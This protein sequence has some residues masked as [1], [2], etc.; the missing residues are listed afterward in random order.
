MIDVTGAPVI[1]SFVDVFARVSWRRAPRGGGSC[2]PRLTASLSVTLTVMI[3]VAMAVTSGCGREERATDFAREYLRTAT[4]GNV[5]RLCALRSD[6]ALRRWGGQVACERRAEGLAIDPP[7]P[8]VGPGSRRGLKRKA[9]AVKP[10][11]AKVV[12]DDTSITDDRA[13]VVIDFG[14][15]ILDDGHAVGGEILEMDLTSQGDDYQ[16]ARLGFAAFAD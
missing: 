2:P 16:V 11:T 15:A 3:A 13:R 12:P 7:P 14:E 6:A 4:D 10:R 5:K 1:R 9:L 8:S